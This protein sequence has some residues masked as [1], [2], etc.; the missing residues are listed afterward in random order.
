MGVKIPPFWGNEISPPFEQHGCWAKKNFQ[1]CLQCFFLNHKGSRHSPGGSLTERCTQLR[2][3]SRTQG[4]FLGPET[5]FPFP[6]RGA[7][8]GQS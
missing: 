8:K 4:L 2:R 7:I 6:I 3:A 1:M 5:I